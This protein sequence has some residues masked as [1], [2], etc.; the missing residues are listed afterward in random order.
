MLYIVVNDVV[1]IVFGRPAARSGVT[2]VSC[3]DS[4]TVKH[5]ENWLI[6]M[7]HHRDSTSIHLLLCKCERSRGNMY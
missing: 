7:H 2:G 6:N 1:R 4:V 5:Q 3:R